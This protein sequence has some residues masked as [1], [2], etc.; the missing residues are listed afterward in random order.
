VWGAAKYAMDVRTQKRLD[1]I[2]T[3]FIRGTVDQL[4]EL[5]PLAGRIHEGDAAGLAELEHLTHQ[6]HGSAAMFRFD[7][8]SAAAGRINKLLKSFEVN[9]D[10]WDVALLDSLLIDFT[11]AVHDAAASR[12]RRSA[13]HLPEW[14]DRSRDA[15]RPSLD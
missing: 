14:P 9:P 4:A 8:V 2:G 13:D 10:T 12:R 15:T 1:E 5:Q 7:A 3:R 6:L 11:D